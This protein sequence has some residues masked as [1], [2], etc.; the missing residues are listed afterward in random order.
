[1]HQA[2]Q[3]PQ[4]PGADESLHSGAA[5]RIVDW[6]SNAQPLY[7]QLGRPS[8][9]HT[10]SSSP[11][12]RP[13]IAIVGS[14]VAG[15]GAAHALQGHADI[16]LFES[17][18][19]FGGHACTVDVTLP[20]SETGERVSHG[21][22]T[23]FLVMNEW[24][25]PNLVR[26][27]KSLR[28]PLNEADMGFSASVPMEGGGVLEWAGAF[29]LSCSSSLHCHPPVPQPFL[30]FQPLFRVCSALKLA[31]PRILVHAVWHSAFQPHLQA[32]GPRRRLCA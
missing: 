32:P 30:R 23:G 22:D 31:A 21:V 12:K 15:L 25:Y 29:P 28:I 27:F 8:V 1:M 20:S 16:T 14:G 6:V 18:S 26:L 10:G 19:Y 24:T 13:R 9:M 5:C 3:T 11:P 7:A 2:R 4:V 17:A